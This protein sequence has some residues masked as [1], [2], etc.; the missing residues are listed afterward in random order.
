M[1]DLPLFCLSV[2]Y[3]RSRVLQDSNSQMAFGERRTMKSSGYDIRVS[4]LKGGW[5]D[6]SVET[7]HIEYYSEN[8]L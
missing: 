4:H 8:G 5:F 6:F 7:S 2:L 3:C 1:P